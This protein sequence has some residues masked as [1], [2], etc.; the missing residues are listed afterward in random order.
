[1]KDTQ[2]SQP[3]HNA[4]LFGHLEIAKMLLDR[5][6]DLRARDNR[7]QTPLHHACFGGFPE[8]VRELLESGEQLNGLKYKRKVQCVVSSP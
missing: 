7:R 5:K 6:A 4:C 3:L 1:M 8:I 2:G